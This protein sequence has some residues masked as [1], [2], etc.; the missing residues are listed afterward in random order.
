MNK[1]DFQNVEVLTGSPSQNGV[2]SM[3]SFFI[4]KPE[5]STLSPVVLA[6][7]V[8]LVRVLPNSYSVE[9]PAVNVNLSQLQES[10]LVNLLILDNRTIN[11]E[12]IIAIHET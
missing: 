11:D 2:D 3:L 9:T 1:I 10:N 7:I 8:E 4:Q 12:V 5:G 6:T